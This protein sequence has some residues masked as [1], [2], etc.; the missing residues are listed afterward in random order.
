MVLRKKRSSGEWE[1]RGKRNS[2]FNTLY[3]ELPEFMSTEMCS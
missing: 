2:P 3:L 1:G